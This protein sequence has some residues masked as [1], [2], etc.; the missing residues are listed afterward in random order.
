MTNFASTY[1]EG[2]GWGKEKSQLH[3]QNS[4]KLFVL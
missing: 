4:S 2:K 3:W 1:I